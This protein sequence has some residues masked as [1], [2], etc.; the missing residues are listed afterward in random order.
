MKTIEEIREL[1]KV[2]K[3]LNFETKETKNDSDF[4]N[5]IFNCFSNIG[6]V[7]GLIVFTFTIGI[8]FGIVTFAVFGF[9]KMKNLI[10][11]LTKK[12]EKIAENQD[13]NP[14]QDVVSDNIVDNG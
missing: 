10:L 4:R 14:V 8:I 12:Q 3:S 6:L 9:V 11:K 5:K 7:L 2:D 13:L 1:M